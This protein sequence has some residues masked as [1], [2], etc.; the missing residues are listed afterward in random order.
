MNR[1]EAM[2]QAAALAGE[3]HERAHVTRTDLRAVLATLFAGGGP[4]ETR[5]R[6]ARGLV[7]TLPQTWFSARSK[8]SPRRLQHVSAVLG[9]YLAQDR[10]EGDVRFVL[11]WCARLLTSLERESPSSDRGGRR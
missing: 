1:A 7:T 11:G 10:P 8:D 2:E 5:L 4:W 9:R 6:A 3:L